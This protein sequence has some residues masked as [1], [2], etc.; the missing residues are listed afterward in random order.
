MSGEVGLL[1]LRLGGGSCAGG[2]MSSAFSSQVAGSTGADPFRYACANC[3]FWIPLLLLLLLLLLPPL[4]FFSPLLSDGISGGSIASDDLRRP[5][6]SC[7]GSAMLLALFFS[8]RRDDGGGKGG[9]AISLLLV[10][11]SPEAV[12][13]CLR[14]LCEPCEL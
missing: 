14:E 1:C 4:L 5:R 3:T 2:G 8:S 10:E 13:D 11:P 7:W 12:G 6:V 9:G